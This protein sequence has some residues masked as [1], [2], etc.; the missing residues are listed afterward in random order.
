MW[1]SLYILKLFFLQ[2]SPLR[3]FQLGSPGSSQNMRVSNRRWSNGW[4]NWKRRRQLTMI[5]RRS[6]SADDGTEEKIVSCRL[7][8]RKVSQL[9]KVF[10]YKG[11]QQVMTTRH[12]SQKK[13]E[14]GK[15]Q[16][17]IWISTVTFFSTKFS[18]QT[19]IGLVFIKVHWTV[20]FFLF[21]FYFILLRK[22]W[23]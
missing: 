20:R 7:P 17:R 11:S 14:K 2:I 5:P 16:N 4:A 21:A 19:R 13:T 12:S 1:I 22:I 15:N 9:L 3:R 8:K 6:E 18:F 10:S 23:S